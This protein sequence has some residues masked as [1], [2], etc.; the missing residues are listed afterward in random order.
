MKQLRQPLEGGLVARLTG[1]GGRADFCSCKICI[2]AIPGNLI[3]AVK[4]TGTYSRRPVKRVTE[5]P[6]SLILVIVI[7]C[8]F[9]RNRIV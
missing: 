3:V 1:V 5:P 8:M 4:P 6:Q 9:L 2:H 7:L